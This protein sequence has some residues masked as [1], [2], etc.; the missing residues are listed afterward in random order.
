M[1]KKA[2]LI[3]GA[4]GF[5]GQKVAELLLKKGYEVVELIIS[6]ITMMFFKKIQTEFIKTLQKLYLL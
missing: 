2:I 3:T 5:S 1:E 6:M 4:G